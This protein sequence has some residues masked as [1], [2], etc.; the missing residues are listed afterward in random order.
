VPL[1]DCARKS[2]LDVGG[3]Q[4][5][6]RTKVISELDELVVGA[7]NIVAELCMHACDAHTS[8]IHHQHMWLAER[9]AKSASRSDSRGRDNG[10]FDA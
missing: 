4:C 10:S 9:C 1:T 8:C 3:A 5:E 6:C 2:R 7:G